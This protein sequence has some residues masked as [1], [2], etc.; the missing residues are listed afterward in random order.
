MIILIAKY[1]YYRIKYYNQ[2]YF[3][4]SSILFN[5]KEEYFSMIVPRILL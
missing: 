5:S 3:L 1:F 4:I 2:I